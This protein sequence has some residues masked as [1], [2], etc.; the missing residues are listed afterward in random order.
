MLS[1]SSEDEQ[2]LIIADVIFHHIHLEN[3]EWYATV[4]L[5]PEQIIIARHK[6]FQGSTA[7]KAFVHAFHFHFPFPGLG[8]IVQKGEAFQ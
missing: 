5:D 1:I 2:L 8:Y 6:L 7:D 3:V 4:D